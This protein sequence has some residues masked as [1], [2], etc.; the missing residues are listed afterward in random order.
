MSFIDVDIT[1]QRSWSSLVSSAFDAPCMCSGAVTALPVLSGAGPGGRVKP[2]GAPPVPVPPVTAEGA[3]A[4]V[5]CSWGAP[6]E[7]CINIGEAGGVC[8]YCSL[9]LDA[10]ALPVALLRGCAMALGRNASWN[11]GRGISGL[12]GRHCGITGQ[13]GAFGRCIKDRGMMGG[14]TGSRRGL[15]SNHWSKMMPAM[16]GLSTEQIFH[17]DVYGRTRHRD[18]ITCSCGPNLTTVLISNWPLPPSRE[19]IT[20]HF[21]LKD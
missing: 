13:L 10:L 9:K 17:R 18:L 1:V 5:R 12:H 3:W 14:I 7:L 8:R 19:H 4:A 2:L 21:V 15:G 20:N 16:K 6:P 11:W